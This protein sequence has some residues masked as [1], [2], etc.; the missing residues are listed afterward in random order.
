MNKRDKI[1]HYMIKLREQNLALWYAKRH[2][3]LVENDITRTEKTIDALKEDLKL[4]A[5]PRK[6]ELKKTG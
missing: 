6:E 5:E 2:V 4:A 3:N 1:A